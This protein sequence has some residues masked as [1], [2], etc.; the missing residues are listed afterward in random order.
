MPLD[1]YKKYP[2]YSDTETYAVGDKVRFNSDPLLSKPSVW[3]ATNGT[4]GEQPSEGGKNWKRY[5]PLSDYLREL[6]E[7]AIT[8]TITKFVT[9]KTIAVLLRR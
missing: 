4:T 7:K 8:A 1:Y 9:E 3:I 6:N 2:E 5:N